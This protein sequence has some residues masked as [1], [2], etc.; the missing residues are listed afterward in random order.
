MGAYIFSKYNP[1]WRNFDE[2]VPSDE[3]LQ[4]LPLAGLR[5]FFR[6]V[7][8]VDDFPSE[9]DFNAA[10]ADPSKGMTLDEFLKF[11]VGEDPSYLENGWKEV[12]TGRRIQFG[13]DDIQFDGNFIQDC[14]GAIFGFVAVKG[15]PGGIFEM[16][17][18]LGK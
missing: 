16:D 6:L 17:L 11:T 13:D 10:C 4:Y 18:S 9:S 1:K 8:K 5:L 7:A 3:E 14:P 2:D 12:Y 15:T